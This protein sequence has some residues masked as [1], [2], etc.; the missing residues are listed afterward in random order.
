MNDVGAPE[1]GS[2]L[3]FRELFETYP[4]GVFLVD[5]NGRIVLANHRAGEQF[6]YRP[7]TL[8]GMSI[9]TLV[10]ERFRAR[11]AERRARYAAQP[12]ARNMGAGVSLYGL[13]R[14]G[15]EFPCEI[16]L[17]PVGGNGGRRFV[18]S[19]R[20]V[21]ELVRTKQAA[22]F[23]RYSAYVARFGMEALAEPEFDKV[24]HA[25][26][27]LVAEAMQV[28][29]VLVLRLNQERTEFVHAA[30]FGVAA[31]EAQ[32]ITIPNTTRYL[33]GYIAEHRSTVAMADVAREAR[34][35]IPARITA[36]GF[37][38]AAGVPLLDREH[39]MGVLTVRT[40]APREYSNEDLNF[41]QS[42]ANILATAQQR[43]AAEERLLHSQRLEA[44]GQL[45]GGVAHD[46]NNL[47]MVI[48]GN[49]QILEDVR[50]GDDDSANLIRAASVAAER[51]AMLTR[52]LLAFARKQP[53]NTRPFDPNQLLHDFRDLVQRTLGENIVVRVSLDPSVP[54]LIGDPA[55]L[56]TALLNLAVNARDAMP[57]GG[58]LTLETRRVSVA[59]QPG[60]G[61]RELLH[62]G[63]YV[64][65]SVID[66]GLGMPSEVATRAFDPFFTTK[67]PG[68]GSGLGLS[69]VYG[70]AQQSGGAARLE[71]VPG[72]GTTVKI[73][74][75][76]PEGAWSIPLPDE[77]EASPKGAEQVLVVEDNDGV[78]AITVRFLQQLGYGVLEAANGEAALRLLEKDAK[79]DL[80]FCDMMLPGM[81]G[82]TLAHRA[83]AA[84]PGI[85]ILYTSGYASETIVGRLPTDEARRFVAKP[86]RR[87]DLAIAVRAALDER[88]D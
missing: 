75:P 18:A 60:E 15:S 49:L 85:A 22:I 41:L 47:L 86:F 61:A 24:L 44:L 19:V 70:F 6:G 57:G 3:V 11:H 2:A 46:F 67:E 55:Q 65:V 17:S 43:S 48:G 42:I 9:D 56:E 78:R 52:K 1:V 25:L 40:R 62:P 31:E 45:T 16:A 51:G 87:E 28:D 53:L 10:P 63:E 77:S 59:A 20:D 84:R 68:K 26:P 37:R 21:S 35:E 8:V 4:D 14:D 80:I 64:I 81:D 5:E 38:S 33:A 66:S 79:V 69:M 74:L 54:T 83:R 32:R 76:V 58:Y 34:F 88:A 27:V 71:S 12:G 29:A 36:L 50:A 13:R 82:A 23:G 30:A 39:V 73:Y 72:R 7:D